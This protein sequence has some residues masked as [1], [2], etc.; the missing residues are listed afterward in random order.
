MSGLVWVLIY[1]L[2]GWLIGWLR[3]VDWQKGKTQ[4]EIEQNTHIDTVHITHTII[5]IYLVYI[6]MDVWIYIYIEIRLFSILILPYKVCQRKKRVEWK[7]NVEINTYKYMR[8]NILMICTC[9]CVCW[10]LFFMFFFSSVWVWGRACVGVGVIQKLWMHFPLLHFFPLCFWV[11]SLLVVFVFYLHEWFVDFS[12]S[13]FLRSPVF[14]SECVLKCNLKSTKWH[15][16]QHRCG[17]E[18]MRTFLGMHT[19]PRD[20]YAAEVKAKADL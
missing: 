7:L 19:A 6:Y 1:R 18:G 16:R 2:I 13:V 4:T 3:L 11:L 9:P 12:I 20:L 17:V 5:Y 15:Y 10:F 8:K 14:V